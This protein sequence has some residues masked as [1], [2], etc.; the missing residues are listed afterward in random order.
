MDV[1]NPW[2][3]EALAED[4]RRL[5]EFKRTRKGVP[6]EEVGAWMQSWGT[7][8]ELPPPKVRKL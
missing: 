1:T 2:T 4:A 6:S 3:A 5:A 8:H 7:D